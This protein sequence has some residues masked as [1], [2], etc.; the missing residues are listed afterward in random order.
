[1]PVPPYRTPESWFRTGVSRSTGISA[2][3]QIT[4]EAGGEKK[5][6]ERREMREN[7]APGSS[8][9]RRSHRFTNARVNPNK[10]EHR[11]LRR[12][13]RRGRRR[14][15]IRARVMDLSYPVHKCADPSGG[16]PERISDERRSIRAEAP[17]RRAGDHRPE[18]EM[19]TGALS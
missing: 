1:V 15:E 14:Q 12:S 3:A 2:E 10:P 13:H 17:R 9:K 18:A 16:E 8:Q 11:D 6:G 19:E 5:T 4:P 7:G